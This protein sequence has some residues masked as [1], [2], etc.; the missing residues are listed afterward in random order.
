MPIPVKNLRVFPNPYIHGGLDHLGRPAGRT[1]YDPQHKH[2]PK[3]IGVGAKLVE[4]VEIAE[5]PSFKLGKKTFVTGPAR[6][7]HRV[8][9]SR[10]VIELP[11]TGYYRDAIVTGV[12][13]A[14]DVKTWVASGGAAATFVKPEEALAKA[15]EREIVHFNA[16]TGE[17][18]HEEMGAFEPIWFGADDDSEPS[19]P[20]PQ[21]SP[22]P[23][24][25]AGRKNKSSGSSDQTAA[26]ADAK[27]P[28]Q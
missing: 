19:D 27:D 18:A 4:V 7:D 20:Q 28:S 26:S 9:Y 24:A 14:A 1:P 13:F 10:D 15:R 5:A 2:A 21:A 8:A 6:H 12:L 3:E 11:N 16:A 25:A 23:A 17:N 22:T